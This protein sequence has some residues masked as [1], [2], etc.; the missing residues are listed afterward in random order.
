MILMIS[1]SLSAP[2]RLGGW[3]RALL[4]LTPAV[5]RFVRPPRAA[6]FV[7]EL[8]RY[9]MLRALRGIVCGMPAL[10][11]Q[12]LAGILDLRLDAGEVHTAQR[13]E[14]LMPVQHGLQRDTDR[15]LRQGRRC[16][17]RLRWLAWC[18][19]VAVRASAQLPLHQC[20]GPLLHASGNAMLAPPTRSPWEVFALTRA[21]TDH[22][23]CRAVGL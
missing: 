23:L 14:H 21:V 2:L 15:C 11:L 7:V 22:V 12:P 17:V 5:S 6:V 1:P 3:A 18:L 4:A 9:A 13:D 10:G 16:G 20:S 8:H 19:S